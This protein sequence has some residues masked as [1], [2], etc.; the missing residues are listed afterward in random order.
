M[1]EKDAVIEQGYD[2][3]AFEGTYTDGH[4]EKVIDKLSPKRRALFE[5]FGGKV[6]Y[7]NAEPSSKYIDKS[8]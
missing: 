3:N 8:K 4:Q 7:P 6:Y 5:E 1:R 2:P